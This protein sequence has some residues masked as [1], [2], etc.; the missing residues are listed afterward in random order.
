VLFAGAALALFGNVTARAQQ[1]GAMLNETVTFAGTDAATIELVVSGPRDPRAPT[2]V[3]LE[4]GPDGKGSPATG[5]AIPDTVSFRVSHGAYSKVFH[6]ANNDATQPFPNKQVDFSRPDP[7]K[8]NLFSLSVVHLTGIDGATSERWGLAIANLPS[9][10]LR[11][12]GSVSQGQFIRLSPA[13]IA[14]PPVIRIV[15]A[16]VTPRGALSLVIASAGFDLSTVSPA[17]V[18]IDPSDGISNIRVSEASSTGLTTTFDVAPCT[19][20]GNR[21]LTIASG[22]TRASA[23]FGVAA[24]PAPAITLSTSRVETWVSTAMTVSASECF[25]LSGVGPAQ[26][27][28]NPPAGI[29][30]I[31]VSNVT[32]R[33][34]TLS[35]ALAAA[36]ALG[37][38]T[39]TVSTAHGVASATFTAARHQCSS[40]QCC[41]RDGNG[42]C[43]DC[44]P[45]CVDI[46]FPLPRFGFP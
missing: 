14:Q 27:S 11:A 40:G 32:A 41:T 44:R 24:P 15:P 2:I 3:S 6:P 31:A 23:T 7:N 1:S 8:P 5:P 20:G 37:N 9:A 28:I 13:G 25:D 30:A 46:R 36:A 16:P 45:I 22:G 42:N 35:F 33:S 34:F 19:P 29:S 12:N 4:F 38:R 26:V 10:G 18:S 39:V 17:Q 43:I 21:T